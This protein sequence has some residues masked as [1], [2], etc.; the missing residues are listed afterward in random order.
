MRAAG[1]RWVLARSAGSTVAA[2]A[3]RGS[4]QISPGQILRSRI[5][6]PLAGKDRAGHCS[7]HLQPMQILGQPAGAQLPGVE[8]ALDHG[9]VVF[10]LC[11]HRRPA[12]IARLDPLIDPATSAIA[13][14][15][16]ITGTGRGLADRR[17]PA[18]AGQIVPHARFSTDGICDVELPLQ[19][20][21]AQRPLQRHR[22]PAAGCATARRIY[23][24]DRDRQLLPRQDALH[25]R[26][27]LRAACRFAEFLKS[28]Q[29]LL[30]HRSGSPESDCAVDRAGKSECP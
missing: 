5:Q 1:T 27:E 4:L 11:A 12:M 3:A 21:D 13:P 22:R 17:P 16:E 24:P 25:L 15:G 6:Q 9:D 29:R 26:E 2:A 8:H 14:I 19:Q 7:A 20:V 30:L 18:L 10:N 23:R 28:A